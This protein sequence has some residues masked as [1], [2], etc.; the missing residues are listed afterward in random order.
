[1]KIGLEIQGGEKKGT[2]I[3]VPRGIRP[4]QSLVKRSVFD[5]LGDWIAGRTV[6]E[7]FAGSGAVGFEALS[8]GALK[9]VFVDRSRESVLSIRENARKLSYT[10]R[11]EAVRSE[12]NRTVRKFIDGGRRFDLVFADPPY[13]SGVVV[14]FLEIVRDILREDGILVLQTRK[15]QTLPRPDGLR[16]EKEAKFGDTKVSFYRRVPG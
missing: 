4:T 12:S 10:D 16:Q 6:L 15:T 2:K 11:V 14:R 13:D 5:S 1:M 9:V 8:R 7:V 3:R